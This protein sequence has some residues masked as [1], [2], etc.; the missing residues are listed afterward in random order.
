[1]KDIEIEIQAKI[2]K[3]EKLLAFLEKEA[4][5]ISEKKQIDEYFVPAHRNFLDT[6]SVTEWLR[7]RNEGKFTLNYKKW[8]Y[9]N[10]IGQYADEFESTIDDT[11]SVRKIL[12]AVDC[13]S[14]VVVDKTRKKFMYKEY[15]IAFD[16]VKGLGD[17]VEVEYKG[18]NHSEHKKITAEMI[19]F[20]KQNDCGK[21]ELNNSGYPYM[22]LF[23]EETN[24]IEVK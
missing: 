6:R 2:E 15:E 1:M 11:D 19:E 3:S 24:F 21:I 4:K 22:M 16:T 10:G 17:F 12:L 13:K 23:P 20:L 18:D 9:E 7:L 5:F 8:H 14:V